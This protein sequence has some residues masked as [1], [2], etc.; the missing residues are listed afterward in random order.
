MTFLWRPT[1]FHDYRNVAVLLRARLHH[2]HG[3]QEHI[4]RRDGRADRV[5]GAPSFPW[6]SSA[7]ATRVLR[8]TGTLVLFLPAVLGP[9]GGVCIYIYIVL[10][11][12]IYIYIYIHVYIYIYIYR[13]DARGGADTARRRIKGG[14]SATP[15]PSDRVELP[16]LWNYRCKVLTNKSL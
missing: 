6:E 15:H 10:C 7:P 2:P 12:Y 1:S 13:V 5:Q 11:I 14:T 8:P 9:R 4:P 3:V 16:D